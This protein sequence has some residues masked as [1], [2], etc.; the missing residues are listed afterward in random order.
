[1][2]P[3]R[4]VVVVTKTTTPLAG[5]TARR[6]G[7]EPSR[8][9]APDADALFQGVGAARLERPRRVVVSRRGP[10]AARRPAVAVGPRRRP[11]LARRRGRPQLVDAARRRGRPSGRRRRRQRQRLRRVDGLRLLLAGLG[12]FE[13]GRDRL[14]EGRLGA[15][16]PQNVDH[17]VLHDL[18]GPVDRDAVVLDADQPAFVRGRELEISL[19]LLGHLGPRLRVGRRGEHDFINRFS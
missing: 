15:V 12:G 16:A 6:D 19:L 9:I 18:H 8:P 2:M 5:R 4:V 17:V 7:R 13:R 3:R 11:R 1:M 14:L 10:I